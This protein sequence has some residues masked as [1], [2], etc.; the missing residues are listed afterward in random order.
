[1]DN[2]KNI[3]G[4]FSFLSDEDVMSLINSTEYLMWIADRLTSNY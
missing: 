3:S 4:I 2:I 1:M